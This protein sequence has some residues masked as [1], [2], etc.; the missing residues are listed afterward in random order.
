[1]IEIF[2]NHKLIKIF[3]RENYENS[4]AENYVND[5]K[6]HPT[7]YLQNGGIYKD[8][9]KL[10]EFHQYCIDVEDAPDKDSLIANKSR[11]LF[12]LDIKEA[13]GFDREIMDLFNN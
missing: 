3:Q 9:D 5:L 6:D 12:V 10:A 7:N 11:E 1:M 8:I 2:K 13:L 4:R